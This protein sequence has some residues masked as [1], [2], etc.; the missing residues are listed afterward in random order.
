MV[1]V[2]YVSSCD[3]ALHKSRARNTDLRVAEKTISVYIMPTS[4]FRHH[5]VVLAYE[6]LCTFEFGI[7][8]EMF[9]LPRPELE[10]WYTFEVCSLDQGPLQ[11]IGGVRVLPRS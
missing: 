4:P 7:A 3:L 5:I 1:R 10:Q 2:T 8:V 11:A 9:G 6:G